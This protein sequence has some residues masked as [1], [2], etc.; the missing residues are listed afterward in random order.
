MIKKL[1]T[2]EPCTPEQWAADMLIRDLASITDYYCDLWRDEYRW[3]SEKEQ[4]QV[5]E[6]IDI[7]HNRILTML[8][9]AKGLGSKET[10]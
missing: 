7:L 1:V 9:K 10:K 2:H 5:S 3:M 6:Q 8:E 4:A